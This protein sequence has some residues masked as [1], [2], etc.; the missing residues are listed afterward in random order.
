M[1]LKKKL[2]SI[3]FLLSLIFSF[4]SKAEDKNIYEVL[5]LIQKDLPNLKR[6]IS[7]IPGFDNSEFDFNLLKG[8]SNYICLKKWQTLQN[9]I[10]W[11]GS[12]CW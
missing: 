7:K 4:N 1:N 9:H 3:L 5:E 10:G 12:K 8:R 6:L 2:V 11:E